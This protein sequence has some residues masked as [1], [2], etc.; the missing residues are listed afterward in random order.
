MS[1]PIHRDKIA[2]E[3]LALV[4]KIH[5]D[6]A[7]PAETLR[8]ALLDRWLNQTQDDGPQT[9]SYRWCRPKDLQNG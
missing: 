6:T 8:A 3:W 4:L 9:Q 1:E 7:T 5:R 2:K